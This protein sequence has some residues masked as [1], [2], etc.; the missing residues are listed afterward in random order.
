MTL[1]S[2]PGTVNPIAYDI[3][4]GFTYPVVKLSGGD[5]ELSAI[6]EGLNLPSFDQYTVTQFRS[7]TSSDPVTIEYRNNGNLVAVLTVT[8]DSEGRIVNGI[9]STP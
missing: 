3:D 7:P 5:I 6:S 4:G 9:V 2:Q 8:Y 1:Y